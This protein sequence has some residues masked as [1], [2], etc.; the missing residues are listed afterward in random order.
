MHEFG[1]TSANIIDVMKPVFNHSESSL[2]LNVAIIVGIASVFTAVACPLIRGAVMRQRT[3]ECARKILWA[4]EA[5]DECAQQN[6]FYPR[7]RD[8]SG[9]QLPAELMQ[10]FYR[11][12]IDWWDGETD[13]G[14]RWSWYSNGSTASVVIAGENVSPNE[15]AKLDELLDDGNLETGLFRRL[16]SRYHYS[17]KRVAL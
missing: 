3:A 4:G 12:E 8:C 7:S 9:N 10:S 17:I 16:A 14:G 1:I 5:L 6:G 13:L 11:N 15:M 2:L